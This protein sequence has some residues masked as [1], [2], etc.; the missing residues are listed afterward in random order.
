MKNKEY[1]ILIYALVISSTFFSCSCK[2]EQT[3]PNPN[4]RTSFAQ[5]GFTVDYQGN[6]S[7]RFLHNKSDTQTFIGQGK[8]TYYTTVAGNDLGCAQDYEACTITFIN[9]ITNDAFNYLLE[10]KRYQYKFKDSIFDDFLFSTGSNIVTINNITY[11][12]VGYFI[13]K[14]ITNDT[15]SSYMAYTPSKAFIKIKLNG[16]IWELIP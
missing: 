7:L 13:R 2:Q 8:K 11:S 10:N 6:E 14:N 5:Q 9:K 4:Q 15:N 12:N 1:S 16:E 3:C